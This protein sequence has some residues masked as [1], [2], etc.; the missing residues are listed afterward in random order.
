MSLKTAFLKRLVVGR[1]AGLV[2]VGHGFTHAITDPHVE[3]QHR[4][5]SILE[6][7]ID[8]YCSLGFH[9]VSMADLL[10]LAQSDFRC[11]APWVHLTFDD[12]YQNNARVLYPYLRERGIPFSLFVS[13]AHIAKNQ[14]LYHDRIACAS[15]HTRQSYFFSGTGETL[16]SNADTAQRV[17]FG[18]KIS[19]HFSR[20][21]KSDV[22]TWVREIDAL[23]SPQEWEACRERYPE[24]NPMT[25]EQLKDLARDPLVYIGSHNSHH[26]N[27]NNHVAEQDVRD[28][29]FTSR[30]WLSVALGFDTR[31]YCFTKGKADDFT[32]LAKQ[33]CQEA[34]YDVAFTTME[35]AVVRGTD[36]YEIPRVSIPVNHSSLEK[37]VLIHFLPPAVVNLALALKR[38]VR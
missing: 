30:A 29:L 6:Q 5:I 4:N 33:I 11:N 35:A 34:G 37:Q 9:F 36:C 32:P 23:L 12:G 14:W 1:A 18:K 8:R 16:F 13:T 26:I 24:C 15:L 2:L 10:R 21:G 3:S 31:A 25:V 38:L 22:M 27:L 17:E 7:T 28:E 20:A 19:A